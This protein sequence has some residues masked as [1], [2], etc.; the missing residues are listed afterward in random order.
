MVYNTVCGRCEELVQECVCWQEHLE[1]WWWPLTL[2]W[3]GGCLKCFGG[4]IIGACQLPSVKPPV[5]AVAA[6]FWIHTLL[7]SHTCIRMRSCTHTHTEVTEVTLWHICTHSHMDSLTNTLSLTHTLTHT[8]I[9]GKLTVNTLEMH[10]LGKCRPL[11]I[12]VFVLQG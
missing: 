12:C 6:E 9:K 7:H 5:C 4:Q 11:L 8:H 1:A 2:Q 3:F 10:R